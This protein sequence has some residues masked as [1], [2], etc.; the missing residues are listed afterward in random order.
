MNP[1][2]ALAVIV[3]AG[4]VAVA[5]PVGAQEGGLLNALENLFQ[6]PAAPPP[7]L[8]QPAR[9][10]KLP[11]VKVEADFKNM[12]TPFIAKL[13]TVELHFVKKVC[14]PDE[15]Q[16][17]QIH[18]AGLM[19]VAN[20]SKHYE[21]LQRIRQSPK[22]WPD[23]REQIDA[24]LLAAIEKSLSA[25]AADR[26]RDEVAARSEAHRQASVGVMLVH[27]DAAL[28]L[29]P[30]QHDQLAETLTEKWNQAWSTGPRLYLYPQYARMPESHVLSSYLTD[31]QQ[32]LW[33]Q[34]ATNSTV[35]FGWQMELGLQDWM[36]GGVE[37]KPF[38]KPAAEPVNE[39]P[40]DEAKETS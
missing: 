1:R 38:D 35:N 18:R 22:Q 29:S 17:D 36:G 11:N 5:P 26:Y 21:D 6:A 31:T 7:R 23:P 10:V 12:Y 20:L 4:G 30:Q 33:T 15:Q 24:A 27:I 13:L 32:K 8:A 25:D 37:L 40:T 28:L 9:A 34:R 3:L 14:Q 16:F 2:L 39:T 19:A